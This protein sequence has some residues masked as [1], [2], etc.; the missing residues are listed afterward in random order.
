MESQSNL[1]ATA[2]SCALSQDR[3]RECLRRWRLDLHCQ[4]CQRSRRRRNPVS[5]RRTLA[6]RP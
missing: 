3:Q 1:T 4:P 6:A 2:S 5:D